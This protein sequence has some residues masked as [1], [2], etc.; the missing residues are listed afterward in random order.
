MFEGFA[1]LLGQTTFTNA[2]PTLN[3]HQTG[4]F[5]CQQALQLFQLLFSANKWLE[6]ESIL[7]FCF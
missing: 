6:I 4:T 5:L 1:K 7:F 2:A 3:D